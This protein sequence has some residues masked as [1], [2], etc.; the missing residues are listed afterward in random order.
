LKYLKQLFLSPNAGIVFALLGGIGMAVGGNHVDFD[1]TFWFKNTPGAVVFFSSA[2]LLALSA[3]NQIHNSKKTNKLTERIQ[4]C[5]KQI[6]NNNDVIQT[7]QQWLQISYNEYQS[8]WLSFLREHFSDKITDKSRISLYAFSEES[9]TF[10][11]VA[12]YSRNPL[13][14]RVKRRSFDYRQGAI[15]RAWDLGRYYY[16]ELPS[17]DRDE[18]KARYLSVSLE[19]MKVPSDIVYSL[20]MHARSISAQRIAIDHQEKFVIVAESKKANDTRMKEITNQFSDSD[21]FFDKFKE[22][23]KNTAMLETSLSFAAEFQL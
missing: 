2:A 17:W 21:P 13:L 12:R 8:R 14:A 5:E 4:E 16:G 20:T 18:S 15:G 1:L 6:A 22:Q 10:V 19:Y 23:Q 9:E 7:Y 11:L 3:F